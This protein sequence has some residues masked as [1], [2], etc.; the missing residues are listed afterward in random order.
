MYQVSGWDTING[1]HFDSR[2]RY[3]AYLPLAHIMEFIIEH[4]MIFWGVSINYGTPRTLYDSSVKNCQGDLRELRPT[5]M[6]GVPAIIEAIR[7]SIM[8][9]LK[10]FTEQEQA[11]FWETLKDKTKAFYDGVQFP[12]DRDVL[13]SKVRSIFGGELRFMMTGGSG[14]AKHTQEFVSF[15]VAP[16]T[17]GFG[18][19]E[20]TG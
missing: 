13:F 15:V 3:L 12:Q 9:T 1:R 5:F 19:T 6:V 16:V 18:M 2:D 11:L 17:G 10:G 14:I 20:T 7:K 4:V 8:N